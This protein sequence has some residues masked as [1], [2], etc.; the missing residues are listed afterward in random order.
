MSAWY[1]KI[2][3]TLGS[4][5]DLLHRRQH[6]DTN[7]SLAKVLGGIAEQLSTRRRRPA[8]G[9]TPELP[10]GETPAAETP[11]AEITPAVAPGGGLS[12][13]WALQRGDS[14]S[15][16]RWGGQKREQSAQYVLDLQKKLVALGYWTSALSEEG[17]M[18]CDGGFGAYTEGAVATFQLEHM[19]IDAV[20]NIDETKVTGIVD[21]ATLRL[22]NEGPARPAHTAKSAMRDVDTVA[23]AQFLQLPPATHYTR[24]F[25]NY[26]NDTKVE[27]RILPTKTF[28]IMAD[29]WGQRGL[30]ETIRNTARDWVETKKHEAL[31]VGDLSLFAG[32]PMTAHKTHRYGMGADIDDAKYCSVNTDTFEVEASLELANLFAAHGA[33]C[34]YFNCHHVISNCAVGRYADEHHHH[35]HVDR[36]FTATKG[37][38]GNSRFTSC[39]NCNKYATCERKILKVAKKTASGTDT[40]PVV[41]KPN[42]HKVESELKVYLNRDV[43]AVDAWYVAETAAPPPA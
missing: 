25:T 12:I 23:P 28:R 30:I 38:G 15:A 32:G 2:E 4:A 16:S 8:A 17:G 11:A 7:G 1:D 36:E 27:F 43:A 24:Y 10:P 19:A 29:N 31:L 6:T 33:T 20:G 22:I 13:P 41:Y 18:A 37:A 40:A 5:T 21:E 42:T 9:A 39:A 26:D 35:F 34:I 14:D 3:S